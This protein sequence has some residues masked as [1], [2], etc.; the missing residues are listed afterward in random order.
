MLHPRHK[1][2]YFA[3]AKWQEE[4]IRTAEKLVRSEFADWLLRH[5]KATEAGTGELTDD[6][7]REETVKVRTAY[8]CMLSLRLML[9]AQSKNIFDNLAALAPPKPTK[10]A[11]ELDSYLAA[12]IVP[13]TDPVAWWHENRL[14]YP[15]LSRMAISYLTIPGAS[16]SYD[17]YLVVSLIYRMQ[18]RRLT[19]SG[20]SAVVACSCLTFAMGCQLDLSEHSCALGIG[21]SLAT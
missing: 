17:I 19:S 2:Q 16:N 21:V 14:R 13:C 10:H 15:S 5:K 18:P 7:R 11:N 20:S 9:L 8:T 6:N 4:W 3:D 12:D 1:L